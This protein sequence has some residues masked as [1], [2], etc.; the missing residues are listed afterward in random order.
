MKSGDYIIN[1]NGGSLFISIPPLK[2]LNSAVGFSLLIAKNQMELQEN[3]VGD[4]D[5]LE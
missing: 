2:N 4:A 3:W 1:Y 5:R